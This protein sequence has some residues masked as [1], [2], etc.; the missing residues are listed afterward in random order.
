[1]FGSESHGESVAKQYREL[2]LSLVMVTAVFALIYKTMPQ[3]RIAWRDVWVGS[4][5]TAALFLLGKGLIGLYIGGSGVTTL[6]GAAASLLAI[7]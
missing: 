7:R 4:G 3:A 1:M 5:V 6:F 2:G